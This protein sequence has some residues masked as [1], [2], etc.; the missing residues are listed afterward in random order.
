MKSILKSL[1]GLALVLAWWTLRGA[2]D[3]P[4][5]ESADSIPTTVWAGGGGQLAIEADT[6]TAAQMRVSFS[7]NGETGDER[8]LSSW[9]DIAAGHHSWLIDVPKG[10]SGYVDLGA[11]EPQPGDKLHWTLSVDGRMVDEQAQTLDAPLEDGWAFGIQ[12]YFDDY[13]SGQ[14]GDG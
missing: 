5:Q 6:T 3:D 11:V 4:S 1:A 14:L 13:A 12:A 9:E 8:S 2:G 7:E 10:V